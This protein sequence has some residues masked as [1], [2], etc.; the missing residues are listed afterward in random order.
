M[1]SPMPGT[2]GTTV[3]KR[4]FTFTELYH[5]F[6]LMPRAMATLATNR[7]TKGTRQHGEPFE[8]SSLA[9]ELRMQVG[10]VLVLPVALVHGLARWLVG[11]PAAR[12][13]S[14]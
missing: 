12:F 3:Y 13:A 7:R 9:E 8:D 1:E 2:F 10:G 6:V 11:R 5:S 4:K 14:D